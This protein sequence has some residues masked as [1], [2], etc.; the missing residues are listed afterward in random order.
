M[1]FSKFR[2]LVIFISLLAF[3]FSSCQKEELYA[4]GGPEVIENS[5]NQKASDTISKL[6]ESNLGKILDPDDEDKDERDDG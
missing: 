6:P 2:I 5:N 1:M 3:G 4:P